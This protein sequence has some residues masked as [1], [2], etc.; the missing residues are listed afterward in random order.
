MARYTHSDPLS[1]LTL[2][3]VLPTER[4][5]V[6]E[7]YKTTLFEH[8]DAVFGWHEDFQQQRLRDYALLA[9]FFWVHRS[10]SQRVGL[11]CYR[12]T[13]DSL[14]LRLLLLFPA[15]QRQGLGE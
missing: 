1:T 14:H 2:Q 6:F 13:A 4:D 15:Y 5:Q 3:A 10:P 11:V 7:L 8:I 12:L 9:Q